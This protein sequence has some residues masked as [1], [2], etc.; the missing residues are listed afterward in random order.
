MIPLSGPVLSAPKSEN[1]RYEQ[2]IAMMIMFAFVV[3][4]MVVFSTMYRCYVNGSIAALRL[5]KTRRRPRV[6]PIP[7]CYH[8]F[9]SHT[10]AD[11]QDMAALIKRQLQRLLPGA[12][13]FLE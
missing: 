5:R 10:W 2:I 11:A 6:E 8:L 4:A 12:Q 9:V 3:L 13:I 1:H 7:N